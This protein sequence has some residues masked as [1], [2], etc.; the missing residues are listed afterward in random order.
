M[1]TRPQARTSGIVAA[2][3]LAALVA[4]RVWSSEARQLVVRKAPTHVHTITFTCNRTCTDTTQIPEIFPW[5]K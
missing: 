1:L 2:I 3:L 4:W 5:K